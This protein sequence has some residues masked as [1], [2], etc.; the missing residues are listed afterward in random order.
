MTRIT[1]LEERLKSPELPNDKKTA[2][3]MELVEIKKLLTTNKTLLT[4]L[5]KENSKSFAL[6]ASL[7]FI[8]FLIYG[9]YVMIYGN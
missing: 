7:I 6:A 9:V 3:E 2:M 1:A 8:C 5:H 4:S